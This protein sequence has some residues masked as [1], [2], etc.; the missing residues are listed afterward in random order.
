MSD[1]QISL[2]GKP[3]A[4]PAVGVKNVQ[5]NAEHKF[6]KVWH[7]LG[8]NDDQIVKMV[9]LIEP[10]ISEHLE[11]KFSEV[12]S[13]QQVVALD[14]EASLRDFDQDQLEEMYRLT[15]QQ[16]SGKSLSDEVDVFLNDL[17]DKVVS[18]RND[19]HAFLDKY[20][21]SEQVS[22]EEITNYIDQLINAGN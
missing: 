19:V 4:T 1:M 20:K 14:Q 3:Q 22:D 2:I 7:D 13:T 16:L 11:L 18:T 12:V 17:A 15:Y 9:T 21:G 6:V 10:L 8:L 5:L